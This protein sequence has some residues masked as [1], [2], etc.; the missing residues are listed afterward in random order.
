MG[1]ITLDRK[2][3]FYLLFCVAFFG[4][5]QS[6]KAQCPTVTDLTQSFCDV[7]SPTIA[8]LAATSN[9]NGVAW[10]ATAT[11]TTPLSPTSGLADGEDYFAD[12]NLGTCGVRPRV[13][14]TVYGRPF[15]QSFQGPC[16]DNP[17]DATIADLTATG[18][19]IQ[20][21]LSPSNGLPLPS[22]TVLTDNTFYYASQTNPDTGCET[23]RRPVLVTVGVVPVPTGDPIQSF[24]NIPGNPPTLNDVVV[25]GDN[26]WY[27]TASSAV[28]IPLS[29][30]LVNGQSYFA[31]T[32]DPPCESSSRFE[33]Q[34]VLVQPNNAGTNGSR[35]ICVNELATTPAFNLFALLGGTPNNIGTW[36]GP[37]PTSN[38]FQG[39]VNVATLTLAGSPYTFT[40]NVSSSLCAPA[41]S[42][43]TITILPVPTVTIAANTT[44]CS[45]TSATVTFTGTP[46]A[47]VTYTINSG[48]NQTINLNGSG[49]AT[50]T[51]TYTTT[52]TFNLV[53]VAST[54]TPSCSQTQ[55]GSVTIN[56][57]PLPTVALSPAITVCPNGAATVTFTGT[58]NATITY[59][60]NNGPNQTIVLNASGTATIT[61][62]YTATTTYTLVGA[63][64]ASTPVCTNPQTGSMVVTVRPLPTVAISGTTNVCTNGSATVTFTGT[65]NAIVTYTVNS[66][67]NQT[68][69]LNASGTASITNTFTATTIYTL[70][71]VVTSGLPACSQPQTGAATITVLP[72][73]TA[74]IA[75]NNT[76]CSG[77]AA[78]VTFTGTPNATVTYNINSGANQTIVLNPAGTATITNTYTTTTVF[79]LVSVASSGTPSCSQTLTGNITITVRPL[80]TVTASGNATVCPNASATVTFNGTPNATIT[81][82]VNSGPN[83]TITLNA[84]GTA[85][86]TNT[87]AATTVYTIVGAA[88]GGTPNCSQPQ[89]GNVTIT[90]TPLPTVTISG[91]A[92]VCPNG[93]ATI[94]FTGTPNATVTYTVNNGP[95]QTLVLNASGTASITGNYT[96]TTVYTLVGIATSGTPS[97][98][99]PQNGAATITVTPLPT[100]TIASSSTICIGA[101]ATATFTGTPNAI[102]TYTVNSGPNQTIALNAAGTASITGVF[103]ATTVYTLVSVATSGTPSCSQPAVGAITITVVPPPTVAITANANICSGQSATVTFTGTPNAT[104]TYTINSGANQTV[105]L[106]AAGTATIT[107]TYTATSIFNL[108]GISSAGTPGCSQPATGTV[109]ITVIPP[110]TVTIAANTTICSGQ[111]ATVTFTGTPN[112]TVTYTVNNGPTQT[113]VLNATG[114]ATLTN[115]YTANTTINLVSVATSG[116]PSC[117]QPASGT[118][119]ISVLP[120]PVAAINA[121]TTTICS[122]TTAAITFTG[123]P[124]ATVTYTIN[125]GPNQTI[126]LNASG[127]ATLSNTYTATAIFNLVSVATTGSPGCSQP[128]TGTA[129]ITVVPPPTI[130]AASSAST[131]CSGASATVTFTG[132]PNATVSYTINNGP[133]QTIVLNATGT[134]A[135]TNTYT[136][137]IVFTITSVATSGTPSCSQPQTTTITINV[138]PLPTATVGSDSTICIGQTASVTFTGTPNATVTYTVNNGPNQTI[139]LDAAGTATLTNTYTSDATIALVGVTTSGIPSCSQP[140]SGGAVITVL[141]APV[142]SISGDVTTCSGES[143]TVTFTGTPNATI[144][145]TVNNGP[146]QT[147]VLDGSGNAELD[148][149][150]TVTTVFTLV[151]VTSPG[152][153]GCVQPV[154]G[155]VTIDIIAL[156]TVAITADVTICSGDSAT[157]TFTGTPD[158]QVTYNIDGGDDE[159]ILLDATGT[160][161]ITNTYTA[162]TVFNVTYITLVTTPSCN[163]DQT[164]T[165]T[166]TVE[167]IPTVS[168][169]GTAMVCFGASAPITFSGT[170]N[171]T[172]VYTL[173]GDTNTIILDASGNATITNPFT[174]DSTF[175]LVSVTT[176]APPGCTQP[177][178]GT[179]TITVAPLPTVSITTNPTVCA[180]QSTTI[181]FTGTPNATVTYNINNA[182]NLTIVLD[183]SGTATI[184]NTF[185]ANATIALVSIQTSAPMSCKLLLGVMTTITVTPLPTVAITTLNTTICSGSVTPIRFVG[186]PNTIVTYTANG[187]T[188]TINIGASGTAILSNPYTTTTVINLVSVALA[189]PPGCSQT[190][191]GT[192]TITVI[193]P[194]NAGSNAVLPLCGNSAPQDLFLLLGPTA[195]T[196]GT[197]TP[198]LASGTGVF[199]PAVDTAGTYIYTVVGTPPCIND[200]ASASVT[201]TPQTDAGTDGVAN[202]CSNTDPIDLFTFLGGTPQSGGTWSPALPS[203]SGILNPG[204]DAPGVYTYTVIGVAPCV[205]D[206]AT[207]T[208]SITPGPD[209]GISGNLTLCA[210]SAAQDLFLSLGGT[211]QAGGIWSPTLSSGTGVFNPAVDPAG[212]YTYTFSG[213]QPCDDD[214][215]TVTV[216]V[217]PVPDAGDDGTA[218]YCSNYVPSDLFVFLGGSPQLGGTWTPALASGTGVF[219]P[220]IDAAGTYTYTVGGGLCSTDTAEVAVTIFQSP[221]A[222]GLGATL[223]LNSCVTANTVDLFDGLNGSQG[224]G[225]WNDDDGSGALTNNIF[226]PAIA[227]PGTYHFTYTVSGGI[228]PCVSDSATVTVI[229]SPTP[230]SGTFA[231]V[232]SIC[233]SV[234]TFD[235]AS[236]LTGNQPNGVWTDSNNVTLGNPIDVSTLAA[237]TYDYTY[238]ITNT[239]GTDTETVQLT[240]LPNPVLNL[241]DVSVA[242]PICIGQNATVSFANMTDGNYTLTYDLSISNV[243]AGQTVNLTIAA[244]AGSFDI[245]AASIPNTGI[246]T[247][248]FLNIASASTSCATV[249]ADVSANFT[250]S[251]NADLIDANLSIANACLGSDATVL[252]SS[253]T[254]LPDGDYQFDYSNPTATPATGTTGTVTVT[255]GAGQFN[256]PAASIATAGNYSITITAITSLTSGCNNAS[257]NATANFTVTPSSDLTDSDL[258]IANVCSGSDAIVMIAN[259]TG[260]PDGDYQFDYNIPTATPATATTGTITIVGGAGQF[261]IPAA[262]IA[263]AGNYTVTITAITNLTSGCNNASEN[264]TANFSVTTSS[265]LADTDLSIANVCSGSDAIVLIANATGLPDGDYQFDYNIPTATPATATTGTVTITGGAGQFNIPAASIATAGNYTITITAITN[266]TSGCNNASENAA[267]SFSVSPV[268]NVTGATLNVIDACLGFSNIIGISGATSLPDGDYTIDYTL[269]GANTATTTVIVTFSGGTASFTISASDLTSIG[270]VT[271]TISQITAVVNPCGTSGTGFTPVNFEVSQPEDAVLN[272]KGNEFCSTDNPTIS[273]LSA[274]IAGNEIVVWY[275]QPN[276][277]TAYADNDLLVNGATYYAAL[278]SVAGCESAMRL[279]VTVDLDKCNDIVIPDGFSPNGDGVNEDFFIRN[280]IENYPNYKLE[281]YNRY[282]N[283][284]YKGNRFTPNWDGTTTEGGIKLGNSLLPTG[285]YFYILEFNDGLREPKQ[286]RVYLN[287]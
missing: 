79:N 112:A 61:N 41:S 206:S 10:F 95:N 224:V 238:T 236:L 163:Q 164:G 94:T 93:A 15:A 259:A 155:T 216:T 244:G 134:A 113:I 212:V 127:T 249:I 186:T 31:T 68:I 179:V 213:N 170:P 56:V 118:I 241:P 66:G 18:N 65:P 157:V 63:A 281:I 7:E 104:V 200:T 273:N 60:V 253:A 80:P 36:T 277:G 190:Q 117:S 278:Q 148:A 260:L 125:S 169:S 165:L 198:A 154:T 252:I 248:T 58:P 132:T 98:S 172:V 33:V 274:N 105:V 214:T 46:N 228:S 145:Y 207:V 37:L 89:T 153:S 204:A 242:S 130:T 205:D 267:A 78:A 110:P 150:Y 215:A 160:A 119:T 48:P 83:Q 240:I 246:T 279:A 62:T 217:N 159:V 230:N 40:Y 237:G 6:I 75:A 243:L 138:T 115:T 257:E 225:T 44:I 54:T 168:I 256:I 20:W 34:V 177:A 227:G 194:P 57:L 211:P 203:G 220:L 84:A 254:G 250:I 202:L 38:G 109:T 234:G 161:S 189:N 162:T 81:Y 9:G 135:I 21:Y 263:T 74:T 2:K 114:T 92:N 197:W 180:G 103:S 156:P 82:T 187:N 64:S 13:V 69:N 166:I 70:V 14:V 32:V 5:L 26:N 192:V 16:V 27:A 275:D 142:A 29:T 218:I 173:N 100:A 11:S 171:A 72:P 107:N 50:I 42:T 43:V 45:Q 195:Q 280:L 167:P 88:T 266:L 232:Q 286:G 287:R 210:N 196:G 255:G 12:D 183:A 17:N 235:L 126:V 231:G 85:T 23:S 282:G 102:V 147:I 149:E 176:A 71:S 28:A 87:Y 276:G 4:S 233:T 111:S 128:Q 73:P 129:T 52:T 146:N 191:T 96:V 121:T 285:V 152:P 272:E 188:Q 47:A 222:G 86:I 184:T 284:V 22:T 67:P 141:S 106:N 223:L 271:L 137:T 261:N 185:T 182:E 35:S 122:G 209:A 144:T 30:P 229:V 3:I 269:T 174:A 139:I 201:V 181:T 101:S 247:V 178:T 99:Q 221:N 76:I 143:A 265:D 251:P 131:I 219:N 199:N 91:T 175:N 158:A 258:T 123:T 133:S 270:T 25:S 90:V 208:V 24:C 136:A 239:C 39:T 97:C 124:N 51:N 1:I 19:N 108:V 140:L 264:A 49:T 283:I 120:L 262:S 245:P 55:S 77:S 53:S 116:T 59:T 151:S 8:S 193:P 226:N 268:P